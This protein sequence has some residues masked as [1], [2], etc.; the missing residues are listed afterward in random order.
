MKHATDTM[1]IATAATDR[2]DGEGLAER[3]AEELR[4]ALGDGTI[5]LCLL[6]ASAHFEDRL[7]ALALELHERIGARTFIGVTGEGA[8]AD[9]REY[10]SRP[11]LVLWGAHLPGVS[12][13]SFHLAKEDLERLDSPGAF[14]E[15]LSIPIDAAPYFLLFADPFTFN[16]TPDLLTLLERLHEAYPGRPVIGGLASAADQPGQ[17]M[18][19]FGGQTL[20][21]GL[22]GVA[23]WGNIQIDTVV[24]QGCRPIGQHHVI[25]RAD[26]NVIYELG[27]KPPLEW[28]RRMS[29]AL[30]DRDRHLVQE[31]GLLIGCVIN[32]YQKSFGRGD[33]LIRN[34]IGLD[35]TSG[36]LAVNDLVRTGQTIQFHV[37]DA[38]SASED[39]QTLLEPVRQRG[40]AGALLFSCNG[41]GTHLFS[42]RH[43]DARCVFDYG[44]GVPVAGF[45]CAGEIGPIGATNFLHGHTASVGYF[46]PAESRT[47][48]E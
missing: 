13:Q 16:P 45:F 30:N 22:V 33:F 7:P 38:E 32:E 42:Y 31:Q 17:N 3:L 40:A 6:F 37:R 23:L 11:S 26:R 35:P 10:E 2:V 19:V 48:D 29:M 20:R 47:N 43:H 12:V 5:D 34:L 9:D 41:R 44:G 21:H 25:T 39:L 1:R 46:R 27:G 14:Q 18:L 15:Q 28:L 24:S 8:I 36:A 4:E